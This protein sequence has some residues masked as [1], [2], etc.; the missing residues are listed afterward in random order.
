MICKN[1]TFVDTPL[2]R[3]Q[4]LQLFARQPAGWARV[5][6][7]ILKHVLSLKICL[8]DLLLEAKLIMI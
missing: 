4:M 6:L 2:F 3:L 8:V 7:D 1:N 5:W